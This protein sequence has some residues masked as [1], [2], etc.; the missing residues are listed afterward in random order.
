LAR[1]FSLI[2]S[3]QDHVIR[4]KKKEAVQLLDKMD[5][6]VVSIDWFDL[7]FLFFSQ[8]SLLFIILLFSFLKNFRKFL[9]FDDRYSIFSIKSLF[10][11]KK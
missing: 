5:N 11:Y 7:E 10:E 1:T 3:A 4:K 6:P 8:F 2:N 9:V